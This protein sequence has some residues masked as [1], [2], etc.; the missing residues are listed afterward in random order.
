M[1]LFG[2]FPLDRFLV[3]F[4]KFYKIQ[5]EFSEKFCRF[6]IFSNSFFSL[7]ISFIKQPQELQ[8]H[9]HSI[10]LDFSCGL[11]KNTHQLEILFW[12]ISNAN[13]MILRNSS[14]NFCGKLWF[15]PSDFLTMAQTSS[16][17]A[18][19]PLICFF[20]FRDQLQFINSK[21]VFFFLSH[22]SFRKNGELSDFWYF[23]G[24]DFFWITNYLDEYDRLT[25]SSSEPP[26]VEVENLPSRSISVSR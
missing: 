17:G 20:L 1:L 16:C 19:T 7:R 24:W 2:M 3:F 9:V 10:H 8:L 14:R 15:H 13:F 21:I 25:I 6:H 22:N 23:S 4:V 12:K 5:K 18:W 11:L 26:V